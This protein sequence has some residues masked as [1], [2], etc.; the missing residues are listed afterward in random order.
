MMCTNYLGMTYPKIIKIS[1][2]VQ[3]LLVIF[4]SVIL[5]HSK[6]AISLFYKSPSF[7]KIFKNLFPK[8]PLFF[9]CEKILFYS[10]PHFSQT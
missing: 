3:E 1:Q 8:P 5:L 10:I 9:T 2:F 7:L 4:E 6:Y